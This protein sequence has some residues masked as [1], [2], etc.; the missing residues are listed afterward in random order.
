MQI[1]RAIVFVLT[2]V[3]LSVAMVVPALAS[4]STTKEVCVT[5]YGGATKCR[6]ET[7][8]EEVT[9]ETVNAG[10]AE[11]VYAMAGIVLTFGAMLLILSKVTRRAYWLD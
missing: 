1:K 9:H 10:L 7:I 5:Q 8:T 4:G 2:I 6:T 3:L 11:N